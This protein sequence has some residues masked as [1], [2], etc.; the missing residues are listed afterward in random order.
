MA[1]R[2]NSAARIRANNKYAAKAYDRINIAVSKGQKE[3]FQAH[4]A[5]NG[6]SVNSFIVRAIYEAII[7]DLG[8]MPA[9]PQKPAG[10]TQG[11][12]AVSLPP[13]THKAAQG[14]TGT[15]WQPLPDSERRAVKV[16]DKIDRHRKIKQT[17]TCPLCGSKMVMRK[18]KN[19]KLFWGCINYFPDE[20]VGGCLGKRDLA[21]NVFVIDGEYPASLGPAGREMFDALSSETG[22]GMEFEERKEISEAWEHDEENDHFSRML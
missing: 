15:A 22:S 18:G 3:I 9:G 6:E 13:D 12:G 11:A 20:S 1:E 21:G 5:A 8:G 4:A 14:A 2:K 7:R 16:E 10:E 17:P 19:G